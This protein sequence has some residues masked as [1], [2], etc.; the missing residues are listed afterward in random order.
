MR[1]MQ[2][3][4]NGWLRRWGCWLAGLCLLAGL[5][6]C[7]AEMRLDPP[8]GVPQPK[9]VMTPPATADGNRYYVGI[10]TAENVLDEASG[11]RKA[12]ANAGELAAQSLA[13][14]ITGTVSQRETKVGAVH[15][16]RGRSIAV[17]REEMVA[18]I[19]EIIRSMSPEKYYYEKWRVSQGGSE[20]TRYKYYVLAS[21]PQAEYERV[22]K[23]VLKS[24]ETPVQRVAKACEDLVE[25]LLA[26][27]PEGKIV[28]VLPL[29]DPD[30]GVRRIGVLVADEIRRLLLARGAR[31]ADREHLN[32]VLGEK[33]LQLA[34]QPVRE[35]IRQA[36]RLAGADVLILG[37]LSATGKEAIFS[38]K[39]ISVKTGQAIVIPRIQSISTGG[40]GE[41]MWYVRRAVRQTSGDLPP[42]A[43]RYK[44]VAQVRDGETALSDGATVSSGQRFK[45][46][47]QP[48]SDCQLYVLLYDSQGHVRVLFPHGKIG[49]SNEVRGGVSYEI[50]EGTKWY[51]FDDSPGI[52]T[53]Y[54][55]ASYTP[56]NDLAQLLA[57][58]QQAGEQGGT[59]ATAARDHIDKVITRGMSASTSRE[60]Q[61][62]GVT[63]R[64]RGVG[65]VVDI[66]WGGTS[67]GATAEMDNIVQGHAT[68][69]KKVVL[70][71]R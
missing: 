9:W 57:R 35:S 47:L 36:G 45:I 13:M 40:L 52:E 2:R 43:I 49:L 42:L 32:A 61:P 34:M 70:N 22:R 17:V 30:G 56:L 25:E 6:G 19:S 46:R 10:A 31:L 21:Y 11:R 27:L 8:A 64:T 14:D 5:V 59:L 53:F 4:N 48:N 67:V 39:A 12:L 66:G 37:T 69:V 50:P 33:D 24:M 68:V 20:F 38:V 41:L 23:A 55:V 7:A 29:T 15:N 28:A 16:G 71:H 3:S 26:N 65:G 58:M 1:L 18:K 60:Y 54:V 63:V 51:W 62:K 44:F